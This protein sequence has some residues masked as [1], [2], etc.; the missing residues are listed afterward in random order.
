MQKT[1]KK[2]V[3]PIYA[4]A[5]LWLFWVF[6]LPLYKPLHFAAAIALSIAVYFVFRAFDKGEVVEIPDEPVST[7]NAEL[8]ALIA[9][10]DSSIREMRRLNDNIED[11]YISDKIDEI[12]AVT[13]KI[14]DVVTKDME[15]APKIRKFMNYYLP[16]TLK[17]LDAYDQMTE[18][19]I[20]GENINATRQKVEGV[21][22]TIIAAFNKQLDSLYGAEALDI[23]TDITVL[24]NML[25]REGLTEQQLSP[26][27]NIELK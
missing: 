4:I 27:K 12:E 5:V 7:G 11:E 3:V 21:M 23:S 14:F 10:R 24:E 1:V 19:G 16:T 22:D 13:N 15:K 20:D 17:M 9:Q 8:D 6:F 2:S 25:A 26:Q 18:A